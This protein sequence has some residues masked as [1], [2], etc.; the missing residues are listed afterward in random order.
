[1]PAGYAG[2]RKGSF[3]LV[4]SSASAMTAEMPTVTQTAAVPTVTWRWTSDL[5]RLRHALAAFGAVAP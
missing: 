5:P 2:P 4:T 3:G 1:M